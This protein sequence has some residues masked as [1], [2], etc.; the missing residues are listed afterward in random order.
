MRVVGDLLQVG[1]AVEA[2][3]GESAAAAVLEADDGAAA[4][5]VEGGGAGAA[6]A[7]GVEC[8]VGAVFG[9][10][11]QW[12]GVVGEGFPG[13]G[14]PVGGVGA[15]GPLAGGRRL[16]DQGGL[17]DLPGG[18]QRVAVQVVAA[19]G[20]PAGLVV[21]GDDPAVGVRGGRLHVGQAAV[22]G[23]VAVDRDLTQRGDLAGPVARPQPHGPVCVVE[24]GKRH[25][26]LVVAALR[27]PP[28]ASWKARAEPASSS[29][30]S[31][32]VP[33]QS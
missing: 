13:G 18:V 31:H 23:V 28:A 9:V 21:A 10:V 33:A 24:A 22:G 25:R 7:E 20:D 30:L 29:Q 27:H 11:Q 14:L 6:A 19:G 2:E 16:H 3:A 1:H 17:Q 12:A 26:A 8:G 4:G 32:T 5:V 15:G